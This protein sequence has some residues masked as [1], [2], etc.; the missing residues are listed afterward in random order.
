MLGKLKILLRSL[1]LLPLVKTILAKIIFYLQ[2]RKITQNL[3]KKIRTLV[4]KAT[5]AEEEVIHDLPSIAVFW[6]KQVLQP[7]CGP[8]GFSC[9]E[10]FY[11][12][13]I[14]LTLENSNAKDVRRILS[15]GSGNGD[16]E[17][18]IA[19]RLISSGL[20]NFVIECLDFNPVMLRRLEQSV[21]L[22]GIQSFVK[23]R[24]GDFN[25]WNSDGLYDVIMANYSLHHV[26]QLEHLFA[27]IKLALLPHGKFL[28]ADMIGRNG[29]ARWPEALEIVQEYWTTLPTEKKY[30]YSM[31]ETED[32]YINRD[33]SGWGFEGIRAQDILPLLVDQFHFDLFVAWGGIVD[34]FIDRSFGNNFDPD[35]IDD[36][37]FILNLSNLNDKLLISGKIK[38]TQMYAVISATN[39]SNPTRVWENLTPSRAIRT[40]INN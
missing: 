4:E 22:L 25:S 16:L 7:R 13:Y 28:T 32:L 8:F 2:Q 33:A 26:T 24:I 20:Q 39:D 31:L 36:C 19:Q 30:N 35:N 17:I 15:I 38:P 9:V 14:L 27:Q 3:A 21:E 23:P 12:T 5:F 29:H 40:T 11:E 10:D 34:P 6:E 37:S 1:G 18:R